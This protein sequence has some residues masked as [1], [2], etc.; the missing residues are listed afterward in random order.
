MRDERSSTK[1]KGLRHSAPFCA[2]KLLKPTTEPQIKVK[3]NNVPNHKSL[4][5]TNNS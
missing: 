2:N 3:T 1:L 5:V 4:I